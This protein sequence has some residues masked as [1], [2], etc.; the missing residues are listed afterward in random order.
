M[1]NVQKTQKLS[2]DFK[3]LIVNGTSLWFS[4]EFPF[5][6]PPNLI[7]NVEESVIQE[8][9]SLKQIDAPMPE[10]PWLQRCSHNEQKV[11]KQP[12]TPAFFSKKGPKSPQSSKDDFL[13]LERR[14]VRA[15]GYSEEL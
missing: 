1:E 8:E 11:S 14:L 12:T 9:F 4:F 5:L 15:S 3:P 13:S 10:A 2:T 7:P 6:R